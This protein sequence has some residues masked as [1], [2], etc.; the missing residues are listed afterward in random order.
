MAMS[1]RA[2][3]AFFA[4]LV[5]AGAALAYSRSLG[6]ATPTA[7]FQRVLFSA[8]VAPSASPSAVAEVRAPRLAVPKPVSAPPAQVQP[9]SCSVLVLKS[10]AATSYQLRQFT[11]TWST[12][13][14]CAWFQIGLSW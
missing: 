4:L 12:S 2:G 1:A 9:R 11:I 7:S 14:G 6:P 8:P 5:L 3:A 13:G 10:L